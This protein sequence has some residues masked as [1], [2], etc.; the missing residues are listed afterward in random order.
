MRQ[1]TKVVKK[2]APDWDTAKILYELDKSFGDIEKETGINKGS[3]A[4]KAKN[5]AWQR[6]KATTV[7]QAASEVEQYRATL[8]QPQLHVFNTEVIQRTEFAS[9]LS[10][11]SEKA[12]NKAEELI[13]ASENGNDFKAVIDGVDRHSVTVGFNQRHANSSVNISNTNAQQ[14]NDK[15]TMTRESIEAEIIKAGFDPKKVSLDE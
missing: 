13:I 5:N 11:F 15:I 3:V 10:E 2:K 12:M 6:G 1:G 7:A 4:R 8:T 9:R 14:N